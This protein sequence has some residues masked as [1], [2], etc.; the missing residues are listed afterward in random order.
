MSQTRGAFEFVGLKLYGLGHLARVAPGY[1][2]PPVEVELRGGDIVYW[3]LG[4][5]L[6]RTSSVPVYDARASNWKRRLRRPTDELLQGFVRL[7]T[8]KHVLD[9]SR[10]WGNLLICEHDLPSTH[11][12]ERAAVPF[13]TRASV[14]FNGKKCFPC[15]WEKGECWEPVDTWL[16]Y[17]RQAGAMLK[18]AGALRSGK[19]PET[20]LWHSLYGAAKDLKDYDFTRS[21]EQLLQQ[22]VNQWLIL[23]DTR[24]HFLWSPGLAPKVVLQSCLFSAITLQL[25]ASLSVVRPPAVCSA[26]GSS[27]FPARRS[28]KSGQRNFCTKC[29]DEGVPQRFASADY[30]QKKASAKRSR[31]AGR[32]SVRKRAKSPPI[33]Q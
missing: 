31:T 7:E 13:E 14:K 15:G 21:P 2:L 18:I 26:C 32:T 9:F 8:P 3:P 20:D 27:Y 19:Q 23:S 10:R 25:M 24:P 17:A 30:R 28:P 33:E 29:R 6:R 5:P 22:A 16:R 4:R 11:T 1:L 12:G